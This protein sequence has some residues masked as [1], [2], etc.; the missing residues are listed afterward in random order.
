MKDAIVA[1]TGWSRDGL[2]VSLGLALFLAIAMLTRARTG[3]LRGWA[4]VLAIEL[5]NEALDLGNDV[6]ASGVP[7][8]GESCHDIVY[9]MT[10]PTLVLMWTHALFALKDYRRVPR[11]RALRV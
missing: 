4:I 5:V 11:R 2:H 10:L 7:R 8:W 1:M 3:S 9:T 6:I